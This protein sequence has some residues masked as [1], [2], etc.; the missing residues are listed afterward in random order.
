MGEADQIRDQEMPSLLSFQIVEWADF[1][2]GL[3]G[4]KA[5]S[6]RS[7]FSKNQRKI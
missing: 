2:K 3:Q 1:G 6:G 5:R 7:S 4:L